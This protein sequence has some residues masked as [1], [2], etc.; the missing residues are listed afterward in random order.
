MSKAEAGFFVTLSALAYVPGSLIGG[1]IADHIGR[2][3][4]FLVSRA[5]SALLLVPCAFLG[6][7]LVI[8]WLLIIGGIL[9]GAAD[10]AISAM[11][12]DVTHAG[13][14]QAAFSLLYL[15]HNLGFALGP[16]LAGILYQSHMPWL[17]LGDALTTMLSLILAAVYTTETLPGR[18]LAEEHAGHHTEA[19]RPEQGG[20][21]AALIRR[22]LVFAFSLTTMVYSFVY[23]QSGFTLP[24][25]MAETFGARGPQLFG[26]MMSLNAV[27]VVLLTTVLTRLGERFS[28]IM[29]IAAGGLLYALGFGLIY[30]AFDIRVYILS[31]VI[32]T[33]GEIIVTTNS[34]AFVANNTP[35]THRGRFNAVIE[36][37]RG[38]GFALGPVAMGRFVDRNG[39]R[40]VWP[41]VFGLAL[42]GAILVMGFGLIERA[43]LGRG[44]GR[45]VADEAE[46]VAG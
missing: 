40:P 38:T 46:E 8:P 29:V 10:P 7:S 33:I 24:I 13:N 35:L 37:I 11:L 45:R 41:L 12:A 23:V 6:K 21:I 16:T 26:A 42:L 3:R 9:G 20:V 22:P 30:L 36:I 18:G 39:V 28:P 25:Q 27:I 14:R 43:R 17:F 19:E 2:R 31:T 4:V 1:K 5:L 15:G 32:W 44:S 34:G